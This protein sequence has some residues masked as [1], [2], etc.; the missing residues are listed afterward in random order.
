ML[1]AALTLCT[2]RTKEEQGVRWACFIIENTPMVRHSSSIAY[3]R[4][5]VWTCATGTLSRATEL[6]Y[7]I[8]YRRPFPD[9][10]TQ[11]DVHCAVHYRSSPHGTPKAL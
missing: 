9:A 5:S 4:G 1:A 3:P 10:P 8:C 2:T 11:R 7:S 6:P